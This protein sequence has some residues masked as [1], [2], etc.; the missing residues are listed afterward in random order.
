MSVFRSEEYHPNYY[1]DDRV[2]LLQRLMHLMTVY[3]A[4]A[5]KKGKRA[6]QLA[7]VDFVMLL[8]ADVG[9]LTVSDLDKRDEILKTY[10]YISDVWEQNGSV[11]SDVAAAIDTL[12][13]SLPDELPLIAA[14][15]HRH[16][17]FHLG[18]NPKLAL[19][20]L[21]GEFVEG[22]YVSSAQPLN[23]NAQIFLMAVTRRG[24]VIQDD[25][26]L[27]KRY[28]NQSS[29]VISS[30]TG[31]EVT[32]RD[33]EFMMMG[34][35]AV[36]LANTIALNLYAHHV[37]RFGQILPVGDE[38]FPKTGGAHHERLPP[39]PPFLTKEWLPE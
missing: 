9:C 12:V 21:P 10:D 31:F 25:D 34:D 29:I 11:I 38:F 27:V 19:T 17:Y 6:K 8:K 32:E 16:V 23:G 14:D 3:A 7:T 4:T 35:P 28:L 33:G 5:A 24:G 37:A 18:K 13:T 30:Y 20:S 1:R 15:V 26:T 36:K 39:R 2:A 22:V